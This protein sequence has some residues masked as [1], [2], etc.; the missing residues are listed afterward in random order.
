MNKKFSIL[1]AVLALVASTLA[2][3]LGEPT[4]DNVRTAKDQDGNQPTSV[5]STTDTVYVVSDLSNGVKGNTIS[6][7]W[8][9]VD[10][11]DT[12]PNLLIDEADIPIE[13]DSFTGNIYFYFPPPLDGQ[14]PV[15]SYKVEVYFN[16]VLT[17]TVNF[18]VQ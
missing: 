17:S 3:A 18:T 9:A 15:G 4:L 1:L 5:F 2:C 6:S 8:Y 14:W 10:V 11:A 7:K 13:D 16:G 12:E